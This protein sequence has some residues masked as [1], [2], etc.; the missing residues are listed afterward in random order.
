MRQYVERVEK[1]VEKYKPYVPATFFLGGFVFD[2]L[3]VSRID[4]NFQ[5][6]QQIIYLIVIG[7]L[8]IAE[9]SPR[10]EG[11]FSKGFLFK[12]WEFRYEIIHFLLGSLLSVYMIF[13]FRSASLATAI[14]FV[15]IVAALLVLNEFS[16]FKQLGSIMRFAMFAMCCCSYFI[17]LVPIM[18]KQIGPFTFVF[19]V[20]LSGIFF[21]LFYYIL[22]K[23]EH[24]TTRQRFVEVALPGIAVHILFVVLYFFKLLP[25]IPLSVEKMGIYHKLERQGSDF[26]LYYDRPWWKFWQS[27]AQTFIAAPDD[28]IH[29][30]ASIFAP[31]FFK[32]ET[33]MEWW[34]KEAWGWSRADAIIMNVS[35][36]REKGFR[37]Y[38]VK[39]NFTDGDWQVRVMTSDGREIGRLNFTVLKQPDVVH[40]FQTD[41]Y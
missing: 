37:G 4:E 33:K 40:E 26:I 24:I 1:K 10:V 18:W 20:I 19:S 11:W 6:I 14:V 39:N 9:K 5:L 8:M 31:E 3:T 2:L 34:K 13:Y 41:I 17:Y 27:G 22:T 21:T 36:G 12:V 30:F 25:A 38:T 32:D 28:K 35:G 15:G 16:F 23:Y 29:A 7:L